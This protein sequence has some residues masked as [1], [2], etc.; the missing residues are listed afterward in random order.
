VD[1]LEHVVAEACVRVSR[2]KGLRPIASGQP[3][4]GNWPG[5]F[6]GRGL[7]LRARLRAP[8]GSA[9][10]RFEVFAKDVAQWHYETRET[11]GREWG[12]FEAPIEYGWTD[13]EAAAAGWLR[14]PQSFGWRETL[15]HAGKVVVMQGSAQGAPSFDMS[16][17]ELDPR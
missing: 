16:D 15:Q 3:L 17:L 2:G 10:A 8:S 6:G 9:V 13:A 7:A 4:A 11:L 14:G 1:A 5:E 12:W